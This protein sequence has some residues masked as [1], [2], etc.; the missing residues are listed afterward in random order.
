MFE[1]ITVEPGQALAVFTDPQ[2]LAPLLD[3]IDS[4]ARSFAPDT[5]TARGRKEIASLAYRVAQ[6]KTYLDKLG[7]ELVD[8]YKELPRRIDA[9]RK[10]ARDHLD[11]LRDEIRAPLDAWEAEQARI[12]AERKAAEEAERLRVQ[13][14]HDYEVAVLMNAEF[15]RARE[16]RRRLEEEALRERD[17]QVA[18]EAAR[19]EREEAERKVIQ[20]RLDAERAEQARRDAEA[21]AAREAAEA[22]ARAERAEVE[23]RE[24]AER[25]AAEAVESERRRQEEERQR[26]EAEARR[27]AEAEARRQ[28]DVEHR[29]T[30]N[31]GILAELVK[32]G[33]TDEQGRGVVKAIV[34]GRIPNVSI[35]Y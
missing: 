31:R 34:E 20:A 26:A 12:E 6:S 33:L 29:K 15:D 13:I 9:G 11:K 7:K 17:R 21:R 4:W 19:R 8:E 22:Q 10:A 14:E 1:L 23:A 32:L 5:S 25:A 16:E 35:N 3:K 18:E 2:Q 30:I 24:R 28:A 27:I